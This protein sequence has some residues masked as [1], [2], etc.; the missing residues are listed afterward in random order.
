MTS[1]NQD[2]SM[3]TGVKSSNKSINFNIIVTRDNDIIDIGQ[4]IDGRRLST[5][6]KKRRI[7]F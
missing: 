4:E 6:Q 3:R 5:L 1:M 7:I 2:L